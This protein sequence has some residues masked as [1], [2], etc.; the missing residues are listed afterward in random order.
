MLGLKLIHISN[1]G[2]GNSYSAETMKEVHRSYFE[3]PKDTPYHAFT[4]QAPVPLG[5]IE[6][7]IR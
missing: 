5:T 4:D 1:R 2:P 7:E 3:L 6:F